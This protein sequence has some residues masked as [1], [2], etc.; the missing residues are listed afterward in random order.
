MP[1]RFVIKVRN[2]NSDKIVDSSIDYN[3]LYKRFLSME[4]KGLFPIRL[5]DTTNGSILASKNE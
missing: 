2:G 4:S 3:I 1:E 5:I